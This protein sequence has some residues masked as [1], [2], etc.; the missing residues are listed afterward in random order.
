MNLLW[1]GL[2]GTQLYVMTERWPTLPVKLVTVQMRCL[3]RF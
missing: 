1:L 3:S 2:T